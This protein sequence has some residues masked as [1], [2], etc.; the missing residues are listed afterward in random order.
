MIYL[1]KVEILVPRTCLSRTLIVY[2]TQTNSANKPKGLND[3][4]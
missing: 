3:L 2:V 1:K 4:E